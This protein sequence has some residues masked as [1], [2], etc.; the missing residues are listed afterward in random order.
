VRGFL[1]AALALGLCGCIALARESYSTLVA[2]GGTPISPADRVP[3]SRESAGH[4][5]GQDPTAL[6]A[7]SD[8]V[9]SVCDFDP[10]FWMVVFPPLPIP[11]FS[12]AEDSSLPG[13]TLVRITFEKKGPWK[14][15]FDD[16]AL[17]GS[18][19]KRHT[20][21]RYRV[22]LP[23]RAE[24]LANQEIPL[25]DLE[26]CGRSVEPRKTVK[27]A[28]VAVLGPGELLLTFDSADLPKDGR[29]LELKGLTRSDVP[30]P[31]PTVTLDGGSRWYWYRFFP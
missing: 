24:S 6:R 17:V 30:V 28:H 19:G 15:R 9:L 21:I 13:T 7:G 18:D 1:A 11:L 25:R 12:S 4:G 27:R 14:A 29:T 8:V 10:G 26:P 20:P 2:T 5:F 3:I 22:V 23:E 31:I 16:L